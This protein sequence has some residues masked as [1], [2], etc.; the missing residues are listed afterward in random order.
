[1][2][3]SSLHCQDVAAH[4]TGLISGLIAENAAVNG[5][6][7]LYYTRSDSFNA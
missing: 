2:R 5:L 7:R 4:L 1:V 3:L 6:L